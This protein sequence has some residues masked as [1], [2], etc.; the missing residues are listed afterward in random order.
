MR[1]LWL[2]SLLRRVDVCYI[3][4]YS[5]PGTHK[6]TQRCLLFS[7]WSI[8][9]CHIPPPMRTQHA[10]Y[11]CRLSILYTGRRYKQ[12]SLRAQTNTRARQTT[13][14]RENALLIICPA[15]WVRKEDTSWIRTRA[16]RIAQTGNRNENKIWRELY[17]VI[18]KK[19]CEGVIIS[20]PRATTYW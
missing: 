18:A 14:K 20:R 9:Y 7:R 8:K 3:Y 2:I 4:I 6:R 19:K 13:E 16:R 10:P 12:L 11:P 1:L 17:S 15:Y 5:V